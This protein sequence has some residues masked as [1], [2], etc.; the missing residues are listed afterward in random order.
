MLPKTP[1]PPIFQIIFLNP[2]VSLAF[3]S[4]SSYQRKRKREIAS[5]PKV[6]RGPYRAWSGRMDPGAVSSSCI[7]EGCRPFEDLEAPGGPFAA[8]QVDV[9]AVES[10]RGTGQARLRRGLGHRPYRFGRR[11]PV[12]YSRN[13]SRTN[14]VP[15]KEKRGEGRG[16][17]AELLIMVLKPSRGTWIVRGRY[18]SASRPTSPT[19][20]WSLWS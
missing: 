5:M 19:G 11:T 12:L 8:G 2:G 20:S 16:K 10:V 3:I 7:P 15:Y 13:Q 18:W 14:I 4:L 9:G 1:P 6:R 17:L